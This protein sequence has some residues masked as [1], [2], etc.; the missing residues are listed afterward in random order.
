MIY[1]IPIIDD[2]LCLEY[3][4][5][6]NNYLKIENNLHCSNHLLFMSI[7]IEVMGINVLLPIYYLIYLFLVSLF[8]KDIIKCWI[9]SQIEL[10]C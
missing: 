9:A 7:Q 10:L 6:F 1:V 3:S 2:G 5:N 8:I 4:F